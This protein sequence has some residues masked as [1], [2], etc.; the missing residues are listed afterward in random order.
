MCGF[1][2]GFQLN[3]IDQCGSMFLSHDRGVRT[4]YREVNFWS[5]RLCSLVHIGMTGSW[6]ANMLLRRGKTQLK[7]G[8]PAHISPDEKHQ[9]LGWRLSGLPAGSSILKRNQGSGWTIEWSREAGSTLGNL[10]SSSKV[11]SFRLAGGYTCGVLKKLP[12]QE[13]D[14]FVHSL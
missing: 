14:F 3:S 11:A 2:T 5:T 1:I 7:R 4:L 9:V 10:L 13:H 6:D 12:R 8:V